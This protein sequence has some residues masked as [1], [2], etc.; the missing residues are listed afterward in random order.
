MVKKSEL[1]IMRKEVIGLYKR[2]FTT[3][4]IVNHLKHHGCGRKIRDVL[5]DWMIIGL[6]KRKFTTT[7]I[8]NHLKHHGCGRKTRD[9]RAI[10]RYEN[11]SGV[12]VFGA[13]SKEGKLTLKLIDRGVK[14]NQQLYLNDILKSH[15][16][17]HADRMFGDRRYTFQQDSA[18]AHKAKTV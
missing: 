16:K 10:H 8:V 9:V 3:T 5:N 17:S 2:K 14:I 4:E 18:P 15:V 12:M 13:F 1:E 7:E 6:Y 11:A